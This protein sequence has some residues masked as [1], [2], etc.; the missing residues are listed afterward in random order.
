MSNNKCRGRAY[1]IIAITIAF[2]LLGLALFIPLMM[3]GNRN[4]AV[5]YTLLAVFLVAYV[6]VVVI[7]EIVIYKRNKKQ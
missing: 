4:D 1:R 2:V 5:I 3:M 6:G 7:N